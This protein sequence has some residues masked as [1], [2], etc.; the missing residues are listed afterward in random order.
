VRAE[1]RETPGRPVLDTVERKGEKTA[2]ID[3]VWNST[4]DQALDEGNSAGRESTIADVAQN[5]HRT[6]LTGEAESKIAQRETE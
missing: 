2:F 4:P 3:R 6:A 5:S 1:R